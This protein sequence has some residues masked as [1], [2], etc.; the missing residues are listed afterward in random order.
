[1]SD[2]SARRRTTG[3]GLGLGLVAALLILSACS[4]DAA[5]MTGCLGD[6]PAVPRIADVAPPN[7]PSEG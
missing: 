1:M 3:L 2:T 7:C 6:Q 4:R 5:P